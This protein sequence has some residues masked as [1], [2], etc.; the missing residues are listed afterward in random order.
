MPTD[1]VLSIEQKQGKSPDVLI[2]TF[3]GPITLRT[4][5][6]FQSQVRGTPS[7]AVTIFDFTAV[8]YVDSAG[9]GVVINQYVHCQ[10]NHVKLFAAGVNNRALELFRLTK[11]DTLIPL[12]ASVEEAES[13]I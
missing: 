1:E 11:V 9:M 8:P 7:P 12:Y 3:T 10:K 2:F 4:L 13:R 6:E 5:F